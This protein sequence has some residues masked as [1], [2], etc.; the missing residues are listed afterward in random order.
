MEEKTYVLSKLFLVT[1]KK[2][3][4][5]PVFWKTKTN[6]W[7]LS[8][9]LICQNSYLFSSIMQEKVSLSLRA[10]NKLVVKLSAFIKLAL[11]FCILYFSIYFIHFISIFEILKFLLRNKLVVKLSAFI[12]L[13]K[14]CDFR[15]CIFQFISFT[16]F[17]KFRFPNL[18]K[19]IY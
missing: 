19:N 12:K 9:F 7:Q 17:L 5:S 18:F 8:S 11:W 10:R 6:L 16:F 13:C 14:P 4:C 1:K 2:S 3:N 15:F